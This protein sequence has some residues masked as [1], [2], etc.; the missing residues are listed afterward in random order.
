MPVACLSV[1]YSIPIKSSGVKCL[2]SIRLLGLQLIYYSSSIHKT[3]YSAKKKR[4]ITTK[5]ILEDMKDSSACALQKIF[6][7]NQPNLKLPFSVKVTNFKFLLKSVYS[8]L[9][10]K[11]EKR[12]VR[13]SVITILNFS[14]IHTPAIHNTQNYNYIGN[15]LP[16]SAKMKSY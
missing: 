15:Q 7:Q 13:S 16:V 6:L 11:R 8:K 10:L 12:T 5:C 9:L 1:A 14:E 2:F 4:R 3:T